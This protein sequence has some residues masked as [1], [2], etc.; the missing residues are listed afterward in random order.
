MDNA[1]TAKRYAEALQLKDLDATAS[2]LS[3]DVEVHYPQSGEVFRGR[4]N[5]IAM[6]SE[7]PS[8]LP[9]ADVPFVSGDQG[10]VVTSPVPF[11]VPLVS[12]VGSGDVWVIEGTAEY[13]DGSEYRLAV[14]LHMGNGLVERET[15]YWGSPFPAPG[16][17]E[18]FT[19]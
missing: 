12:V 6:L 16:W 2:L 5:Y 11:G 17:R 8:G 14:I 3:A 4:D 18:P 15:W 13:G 19:A 1:K 10:T 7:F 9:E